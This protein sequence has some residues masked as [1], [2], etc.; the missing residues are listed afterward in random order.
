MLL[1]I[2][3]S[4]FVGIIFGLSLFLAQKVLF[5]SKN[6]IILGALSIVRIL[7]LGKFFYIML[8]S[9]PIQPIILVTFFLGAYW[10][11]IL[12]CKEC[13]HARS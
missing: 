8:K 4:S 7:I 9:T 6:P 2:L 12:L 1:A 11:T 5:I 10:L 3:V 13:M